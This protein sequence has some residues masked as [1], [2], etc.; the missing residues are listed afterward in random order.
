MYLPKL[1]E[2]Q[3]VEELHDLIRSYPFGTLVSLG[4]NGLQANHL[5]FLIESTPQPF[6]TLCAHVA[7]ANPV[8]QNLGTNR[9]VL[10]IFQGPH[11]YISPS[12]YIT[13]NETGMVVPTWNYA[14]VHAHGRLEAIEDAAWLRDFVDKLTSSQEARRPEP[15]NVSDAPDQYIENQLGAIVGLKLNIT[16]LVG[17]WKMSQNRPAYDRDN[18][19]RVLSE[20][21]T[22]SSLA[23]ADWIRKANKP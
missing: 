9:D 6:G 5:P 23:M 21:N 22:E 8:W 7:R 3:R 13:K 16:R 20:Q 4:E 2:E 1:F 12:W 10:A 14:V 11:S 17:K 18:V 15:W 19:I